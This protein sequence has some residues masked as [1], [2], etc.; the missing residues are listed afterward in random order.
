[1]FR[2]CKEL[3]YLD[4]SNID[5]S[6]VSNMGAMFEGCESLISLDITNFDTTS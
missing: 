6:K 3:K 4:L 2:N 5:T 1:M